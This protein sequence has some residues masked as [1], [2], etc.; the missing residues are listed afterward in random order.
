MP[1]ERKVIVVPTY[2]AQGQV[3]DFRI[4]STQEFPEIPCGETFEEHLKMAVDT[5]QKEAEKIAAVLFEC[6][7][8]GT[9]DRLFAEFCRRKASAFVVSYG[10]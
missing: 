9:L 6:L 1:S 5:H 7:P 2:R 8:G 10:K 4:E 3:Q